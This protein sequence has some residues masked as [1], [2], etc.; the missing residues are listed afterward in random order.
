MKSLQIQKT[1]PAQ[2][3]FLSSLQAQRQILKQVPKQVSRQVPKQ[4]PRRVPRLSV[5][6]PLKKPKIISPFF[7]I[8]KRKAPLPKKKKVIKKSEQFEGS[9]RRFGKWNTIIRGPKKK[10]VEVVKQKTR[11][12]LGASC[13]V[14]DLAKNKFVMLPVTKQFRRSRSKKTPYVL[15]EKRKY[16]LDSPLEKKEIK[17]HRKRKSKTRVK[18]NLFFK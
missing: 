9:I 14:R 2:L 3:S 10:V 8:P 12:E 15:V 13:R 5:K 17:A 4:V 7:K 1:K 11:K 6:K 18:R 16:R